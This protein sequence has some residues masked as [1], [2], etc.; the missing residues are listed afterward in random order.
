MV[1]LINDALKEWSDASS[2]DVS[3]CMRKTASLGESNTSPIT[4]G[5]VVASESPNASIISA[6]GGDTM[7]SIVNLFDMQ[8]L[9][10]LKKNDKVIILWNTG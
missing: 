3:Y 8:M 2:H 7:L 6:L 9:S 1:P 5:S 4:Q 10:S